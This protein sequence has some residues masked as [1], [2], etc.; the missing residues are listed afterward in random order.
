MLWP[1]GNPSLITTSGSPS[2]NHAIAWVASAMYPRTGDLTRDLIN[3]AGDSPPK[4]HS[5]VLLGGCA[6]FV[7]I[8]AIQ[9]HC[10]ERN[11]KWLSPTGEAYAISSSDFDMR[12]FPVI[13]SPAAR[14]S[15]HE[16]GGRRHRRQRPELDRRPAGADHRRHRGRQH[17]D[18]RRRQDEWSVHLTAALGASLAWYR[19]AYQM[20]WHASRYLDLSVAAAR[21]RPGDSLIRA[22][23]DAE[24]NEIRLDNVIAAGGGAQVKI[25]GGLISTNT[26]GNI[27]VNGGL[28]RVDVVNDTGITIIAQNIYAGSTGLQ[29]AIE[30]TVEIIDRFKPQSSNHLLY[31][32]RGGQG[33]TVYQGSQAQSAADLR[34]GT[35]SRVVSGPRPRTTRWRASAGSGS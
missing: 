23:Y 35:P 7:K 13:R 33:V 5:T 11:A 34:A 26:S 16:S 30:S 3:F 15:L 31:V 9:H 12:W 22:V 28:G 10:T 1:G 14:A 8:A 32:H 18:R 2:A 21:T 25:D 17:P 6:A 20:G 29:T 27:H 19:T 24:A 4:N